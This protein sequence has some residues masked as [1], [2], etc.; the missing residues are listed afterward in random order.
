VR[1]SV[2]SFDDAEDVAFL[3]D[4]QLLVADLDLGAGPLP[5]ENTVAGLDVEGGELA[6]FIATTGTHSDDLTFLRLL[7]G[8]IGDDDAALQLSG[9]DL[10]GESFRHR[11]AGGDEE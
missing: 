2:G 8:G 4:E 10:V 9:L 6:G 5:E 3:H 7:L 1:R 11:D